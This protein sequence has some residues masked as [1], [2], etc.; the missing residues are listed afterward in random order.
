M[1]KEEFIA[2]AKESTD[3]PDMLYKM[4]YACSENNIKE[5][6]RKPRESFGIK[7]IEMYSYF[8]P[9]AISKEDYIRHISGSTSYDQVLTKMGYPNTEENKIKY[10]VDLGMKHGFSIKEV[11]S[12]TLSSS[13]AP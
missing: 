6:I 8:I 7:I 10:V 13:F 9:P 3:R 5:Y 1:T 2:L 4:G 11:R 12:L